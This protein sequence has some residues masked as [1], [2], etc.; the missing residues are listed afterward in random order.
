MDEKKTVTESAQME[1]TTEKQVSP[2]V[3]WT[4]RIAP[5]P[6]A[7]VRR[8]WVLHSTRT[9]TNCKSKQRKRANIRIATDSPSL[10][11]HRQGVNMTDIKKLKAEG[12]FTIASLVMSTRKSMQLNR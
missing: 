10:R 3:R 9:S 8:D 2:P 5:E 7:D 6:A 1:E 11:A 12:L 4:S